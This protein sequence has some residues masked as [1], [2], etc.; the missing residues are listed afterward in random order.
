MRAD[1]KMQAKAV[2]GYAQSA[3]STA[4]VAYLVDRLAREVGA[5]EGSAEQFVSFWAVLVLSLLSV[6]MVHDFFEMRH[7]GLFWIHISYQAVIMMLTMVL[8]RV[9]PHEATAAASGVTWTTPSAS[10]VATWQFWARWLVSAIVISGTGAA[11]FGSWFA[12]AWSIAAFGKPT[13]EMIEQASPEFKAAGEKA[14][15]MSF[16]SAALVAFFFQLLDSK[17]FPTVPPASTLLASPSAHLQF[18]HD[19]V[20]LALV[21]AIIAAANDFPRDTFENHSPKLWALR[22]GWHLL[23]F[24]LLGLITAALR[25]FVFAQ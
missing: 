7:P 22:N 1:S 19:H 14:M 25:A 20:G 15:T 5:A 8:L 11:W 6:M 13:K 23:Y 9:L 12:D 21:L 17:L 4:L 18:A 2:E 3:A 10:D 16:V 24:V